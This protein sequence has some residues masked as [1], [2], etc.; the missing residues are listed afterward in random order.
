[1]EVP[2]LGIVIDEHGFYYEVEDADLQKYRVPPEAGDEGRAIP[3]LIGGETGPVVVILVGGGDSVVQA[4]SLGVATTALQGTPVLV[5]VTSEA[6]TGHPI[7]IEVY[8]SLSGDGQ[9]PAAIIRL[10]RNP[11]SEGR[12]K[13][14]VQLCVPSEDDPTRSAP[15]PL[16]DLVV[17]Y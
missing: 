16:A 10:D 2:E 1:M 9:G 12:R 13:L 6:S 5:D 15:S 4:Q 11:P 7:E 8:P 17:H 14:V 3:Q